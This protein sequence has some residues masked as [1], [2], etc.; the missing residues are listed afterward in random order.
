MRIPPQPSEERSQR[1][2]AG[3]LGTPPLHPLLEAAARGEF[4]PW[5][6]A[7]PPR[8]EHMRRVAALLGEWARLRGE[9]PVEE[10]R[11][12][13][14]GLL[15]DVLRDADPRTLRSG[16]PPEFR[17]LPDKVLHGPAAAH[18][19]REEGVADGELL[20]AVRFHT[21]G[22]PHFGPLGWALYAADFLEPGRQFQEEWRRDLRARAPADL[23]GVAKEIL[24][25]RILYQ[26][27]RGRPL[28]PWTVAFWNRLA[29]GQPWA[30]ASE[31]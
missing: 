17:D 26:A 7:G 31:L 20:E 6:Q 21:L 23:E 10:A 18:R 29:Q 4:P 14:A 5:T 28:H 8:R 11:W 13:A 22:W 3:L 19:L 24:R 27:E 2:L 9:G 12:R 30:N 15:H 25:A 16:L 1:A